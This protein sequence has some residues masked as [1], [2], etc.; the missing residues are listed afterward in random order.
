MILYYP[1]IITQQIIPQQV[2][3]G[4]I[5]RGGIENQGRVGQRKGVKGGQ[6]EERTEKEKRERGN[7]RPIPYFKTIPGTEF[8][9][10]AF[11]FKNELCKHYFL[12]PNV[13][14]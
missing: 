6:V 11:N 10:D 14:I 3:E 5:E 1:P 13:L 2:E 12:Y 7:N 8:L 4:R 9:V